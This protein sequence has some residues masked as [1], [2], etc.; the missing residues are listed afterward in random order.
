MA[1]LRKLSNSISIKL[2]KISTSSVVIACGISLSKN[3]IIEKGY[4]SLGFELTKDT[5]KVSE[6]NIFPGA[7]FGSVSNENING[8]EIIHKDKDKIN[9]EIYLGDRPN[10]GDWSKGSFSLWQTRKVYQKSFIQPHGYTIKSSIH[11]YNK[12]TKCWNVV[13][14]LDPPIDRSDKDYNQKLLFGLSLLHEITGKCD[15]YPSDAK[16]S[17]IAIMKKVSWEIFPPGKR[18]FKTELSRRLSKADTK[19]RESIINR[20]AVVESLKPKEFIFGSG[21]ASNYYGALFADDLVLFENLEYGNA[22]YILYEKWEQIS[23]LSRTEI[24]TTQKDFNRIIHDSSWEDQ[25][26]HIIKHEIRKRALKHH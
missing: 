8:K 7:S 17:D 10:F 18:D 11:D 13:F 14:T 23:K 2:G 16:A 6:D 15:V 12:I 22:T 4:D 20:A 9:K 25:I 21:L 24:L 1:M 5:L 26:K 19:T 3:D